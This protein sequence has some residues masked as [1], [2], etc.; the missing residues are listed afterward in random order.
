MISF[1]HVSKIYESNVAALKDISFEISQGEFVFVVGPSGAGKT[2]LLKLMD[3]EESI[4]AGSVQ[5]GNMRISKIRPS[6][7]YFL[8]RQIGIVLQ[9]DL[10]LPK[11]TVLENIT[12]VL[13][14]L[15][16][17]EDEKFKRAQ[18][19]LA[20]V[21]I[22]EKRNQMIDH[23]SIGQQ[24][25]VAIA[26]AIVNHPFVIL[27]DEPTANL[28]PKSAFEIMKLFFKLNMNHTT[29]IMAT[30]DSTIVNTLRHRVLE[31]RNGR[32][33]RDEPN[34]TY[35]RFADPKDVYVW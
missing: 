9:K 12:Y 7:V 6:Q 16:F 21:G 26:R 31:L 23:L 20:T 18:Q 2:T 32:L 14:A 19:V 15:G 17:T 24:K 35:S 29:I 22:F 1:K 4:T 10:F 3:K 25:R 13:E 34:G 27:A 8:R 11:L 33:I 5:M 30:H 28:D